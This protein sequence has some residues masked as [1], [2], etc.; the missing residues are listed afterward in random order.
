MLGK[1]DEPKLKML[2][3][4]DWLHV[5]SLAIFLGRCNTVWEG[6]RHQW[7]EDQTVARAA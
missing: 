5:L 7:F 1:V 6:P 4:I 3:Q 2:R